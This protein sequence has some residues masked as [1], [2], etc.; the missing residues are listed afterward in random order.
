MEVV[1]K[2]VEVVVEIVPKVVEV[3]LKVVGG[4]AEGG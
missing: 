2:V 4:C 1:P 3:V